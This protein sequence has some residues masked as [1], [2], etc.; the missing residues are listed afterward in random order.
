MRRDDVN[1]EIGQDP[2]VAT[3]FL[4]SPEAMEREIAD[5]MTIKTHSYGTGAVA[6]WK[7]RCCR[8]SILR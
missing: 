8:A 1:E 3:G 4:P 2:V 6:A 7:S 5:V